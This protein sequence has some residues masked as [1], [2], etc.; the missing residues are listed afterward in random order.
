[1]SQ[2]NLVHVD[3]KDLVFGQ[4]MFE[5]EGQQNFIN[6]AHVA[7]FCR[8][9]HIARHLHGDGGCALTFGAPH[10]GQAGAHHAQ[11]VHAAV[12]EKARVFDGQHRVFHHLRNIF[13]RRQAAPL[14]AEL[15]DQC[16]IC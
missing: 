7:F 11:I 10:I 9:I 4:Q 12:L 1:M 3:L 15:T 8:Q 16:A 14:F 2:K 13:D 5:L 6:F